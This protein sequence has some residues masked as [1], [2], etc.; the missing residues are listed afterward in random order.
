MIYPN[1]SVTRYF[2]SWAIVFFPFIVF[3]VFFFFF[4]FLFN[5][6]IFFLQ[7]YVGFCHTTM[8]ISHNYTYIASVLSLPPL[9]PLYPSWSSSQECQTG[10]P[11]LHSNFSPVIHLIPDSVYMLMLLFPVVPLFPALLYQ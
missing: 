9:P 5:V 1:D 11:V 7:Y 6:K 3:Q 10:L 8:Q 2:V 4:C